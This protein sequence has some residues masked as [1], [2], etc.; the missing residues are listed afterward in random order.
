M[1]E[2][3]QPAELHPSR[4]ARH[5]CLTTYLFFMIVMNSLAG[6]SYLTARRGFAHQ[7]PWATLF[8]GAIFVAD[9]VFAVA[10]LRWKKWGFYGIV[11]MDLLALLINLSIKLPDRNYRSALVSVVGVGLGIA[12]LYWVLHI[13]KEKKAWPRL[14]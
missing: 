8:M 11:V 4:R 14:E 6:L 9:T 3:T 10:L 12:L 13:G 2:S 1:A 7:P 5:G